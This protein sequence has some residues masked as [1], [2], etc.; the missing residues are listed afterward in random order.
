MPSQNSR[1]DQRLKKL[2]KCYQHEKKNLQT[3]GK[4][5]NEDKQCRLIDNLAFL[6]H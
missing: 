5:A 4:L 1:N 2:K 6:A 3:K